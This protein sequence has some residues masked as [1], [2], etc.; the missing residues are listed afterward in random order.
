MFAAYTREDSLVYQNCIGTQ[1][2]RHVR[3]MSWQEPDPEQPWSTARQAMARFGFL[4]VMSFTW[5]CMLN[6]DP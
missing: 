5:L 3:E 4:L 1:V 6:G 2:S